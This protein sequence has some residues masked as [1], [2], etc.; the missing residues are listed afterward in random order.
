VQNKGTWLWDAGVLSQFR[1]LTITITGS[2]LLQIASET[3]ES[4][5]VLWRCKSKAGY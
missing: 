5:F 4:S 1:R 2:A 3:V